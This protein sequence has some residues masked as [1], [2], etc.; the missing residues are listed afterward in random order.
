MNKKIS[1]LGALAI[2]GGL[3]AWLAYSADNSI[4]NPRVGDDTVIQVVPSADV[5]RD[6]MRADAT[7]AKTSFAVGVTS[8]NAS[9][10]GITVPVGQ[11][12][13]QPNL[14][15]AGETY[16]VNGILASVGPIVGGVIIGSGSVISVD[17]GAN[18]DDVVF[19]G[20]VEILGVLTGGSPVEIEGGLNVEGSLEAN[21]GISTG[22]GN[23]DLT[24]QDTVINV[25]TN[26]LQ[27]AGLCPDGG[28]VCS[29]KTGGL[30]CN[31]G[32]INLTTCIIDDMIYSRNGNV[33]TASFFM[34]LQHA[35]ADTQVNFTF[36]AP[37]NVGTF[38]NNDGRGSCTWGTNG[39]AYSTGIIET[40]VSTTNITVNFF[41]Q[42]I[43]GT[44]LI[45]AACIMTYSVR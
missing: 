39:F 25:Q 43:F 14:D 9:S 35:D 15:L 34:R 42:P 23:L 44:S 12:H 6:V 33:V 16:E 17:A 8:T 7:N 31:S 24:G 32:E 11:T 2:M 19:G 22:S 3:W 5:V 21:G 45:G 10:H 41:P 18:G 26:G 1:F 28:N 29:G 30:T 20:N 27:A 38:L 36:P 13:F 40:T 4:L 37:G